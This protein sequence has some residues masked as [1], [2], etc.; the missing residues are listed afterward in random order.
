MHFVDYEQKSP[1]G[2]R[3]LML[4][5]LNSAEQGGTVKQHS[6]TNAHNLMN[7]SHSL[8]GLEKAARYT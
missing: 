3:A 1:L 8:D 7:A 5:A 4:I 2:Q 6:G